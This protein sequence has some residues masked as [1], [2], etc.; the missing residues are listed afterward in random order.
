MMTPSVSRPLSPSLASARA[1]AP[2]TPGARRI[3]DYDI[4]SEIARG[5]MGIVYR[6]RQLSLNRPVAFKMIL[7]GQFASDADVDRFH[8]EAEAAA[9]L[10]H[11]NLVPIYEVGA[12]EGNHFFTMKLIDGRSM[13]Q[14]MPRLTKAPRDGVRLLVKVCRAIHYAHQHSILH[15]DLKPANILLDSSG[16]PHVTDFGLAKRTGSDSQLTQTGAVVGTPS[17]MAPEQAAPSK[18]PLTTAADVYSLG[19]ILYE[20]LTGRPPFKGDSPLDTLMLVLNREVERPRSINS[21]VDRDLETIAVKCLEK[22]PARRYGSAEAL[23]EDLDRWL[24]N[25]PILARPIGTTERVIKWSRRH[26]AIAALVT[27]ITVVTMLGVAG[28]IWQWREAVYQ[29]RQTASALQRVAEEARNAEAARPQEATQRA[30]AEAARGQEAIARQTADDQRR[31]AVDA[32]AVAERT[33][34]FNNVDLADREWSA[35]N[36]SHVDRL[37]AASSPALRNWEWHYLSRLAHMETGT[38][39]TPRARVVALQ[40]TPDRARAVAVTANREVVSWDLRAR[41]EIRRVRLDADPGSELAGAALSP[42]GRV[43]AASITS[44]VQGRVTRVSQVW[45]AETGRALWALPDQALLTPQSAIAFTPDSR[46]LVAAGS[47]LA[48]PSANQSGTTIRNRIR[49]WDSRT[50]RELENLGEP[51]GPV[52]AVV[53]NDDGTRFLL[54]GA[55][56]VTIHDASSGKQSAAL[57][58]SANAIAAFSPDGR[59]VVSTFAG[60]VRAWPIDGGD[61]VWTWT[62]KATGRPV[63]SPSGRYIAVAGADRSLHVLEAASGRPLSRFTGSSAALTALAFWNDT[64]V[65]SADQDALRLFTVPGQPKLVELT[66]APATVFGVGVTPDTRHLV[67]IANTGAVHGWNLD[68]GGLAFGP[69]MP[70]GISAGANGAGRDPARVTMSGDGRRAINLRNARPDAEGKL[71]MRAS[72]IVFDVASGREEMRYL[73]TLTPAAPSAAGGQ[74]MMNLLPMATA[75]DSTGSAAALATMRMA[76]ALNVAPG[77]AAPV[78]PQVAMLGSEVELWRGRAQM[79]SARISLPSDIVVA[80]R[81]SPDGRRLVVLAGGISDTG[82]GAA[83]YRVYDAAT[84]RLIQAFRG[85]K[86]AAPIAFSRDSTKLAAGTARNTV[87]VWDLAR[88]GPPVV[89]PE[90]LSTVS[91]LAFS[92]DGS[93]LA[94]LTSEGVALFDVESGRPLLT[95]HESNGPLS[96]R[97]FIAS[98]TFGPQPVSSLSFSEDGRRIVVTSVSTDPGGIRVVIKTWDGSP[99]VRR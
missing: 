6:A 75:L 18:A 63:V 90:L 95:L 29:R 51:T 9:G 92:P 98:T 99:V 82:P 20:I 41:R 66:G 67:A 33:S 24:N 57:N 10:D 78:G 12:F 23:A 93:R 7:A 77:T 62:G 11:P 45:D 86:Q 68:T 71:P 94:A 87:T 14:E 69:V 43:F 15:R 40:I 64:D 46:R 76:M 8:V 49:V 52:S 55:G 31:I 56:N 42:D 16:E 34:Y 4:E 85:D 36:I 74:S 38:L 19:A 50:G 25:E 27:A 79:P 65:L 97:E 53:F 44:F 39:G 2:L 21:A 35:N 13:A 59:I 89:L 84:G 5:G 58:R 48:V 70:A 88:R 3:G 37:L 91:M 72:L 81:F 17:Y 32:L 80:L 26:P 47:V 22:D 83:E 1:A 61:D 60:G 28:V 54:S 30:A 73:S 96:V